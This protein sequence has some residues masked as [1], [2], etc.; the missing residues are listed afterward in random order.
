MRKKSRPVFLQC[1]I[2]TGMGML[3]VTMWKGE[4]LEKECEERLRI[5]L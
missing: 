4:E 5:L 2:E 3:L 1:E